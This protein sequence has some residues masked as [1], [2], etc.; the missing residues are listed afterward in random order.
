MA[1][2]TVKMVIKCTTLFYLRPASI[3]WL[4][5]PKHKIDYLLANNRRVYLRPLHAAKRYR[6]LFAP[7]ARRCTTRCSITVRGKR[8]PPTTHAL[9][10]QAAR[11]RRDAGR[12]IRAGIGAAANLRRNCRKRVMAAPA[13]RRTVFAWPSD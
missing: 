12:P 13:H 7:G 5:L 1:I 4:P 2:K 11:C 9:R 3:A 6:Q 10:S 8:A